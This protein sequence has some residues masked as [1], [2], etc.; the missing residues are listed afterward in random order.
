MWLR[1]WLMKWFK[2][3]LTTKR[4]YEVIEDAER[5]C[6]ILT[7]KAWPKAGTKAIDCYEALAVALMYTDAIA[8]CHFGCQRGDHRLEYLIGG[9][10]SSAYAALLLMRRGYYD[11]ALSIAR[12]LGEL[13]NLLILFVFDR[14]KIEQWKNADERTLKRQFS[15]YAVRLALEKIEGLPVIPI[16][17]D[18]YGRLSTFSIHAT[19]D[20]MPQAHDAETRATLIPEFQMAGMLRVLNETAIAHRFTL[21]AAARLIELPEEIK[22]IASQ[23]AEVLDNSI[24]GVSVMPDGLPYSRLRPP[25][26]H[27]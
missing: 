1:N 2:R 9:A 22:K 16:D 3:K 5:T 4:Y 19:P 25:L 6:A 12:T 11:Q 20:L 13:A 26:K 27:A 7:A 18:R 14:P 24:G 17:R 15:P 10:T 8:S 21:F 23:V